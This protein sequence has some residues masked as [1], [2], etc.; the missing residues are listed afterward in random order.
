MA[1]PISITD[2]TPRSP[3]FATPT[4]FE[5]AGYSSL[6]RENTMPWYAVH[7]QSRFEAVAS[8]TLRAKGYE[9]F[10]PLYRSVRRWSDRRKQLDLPLFPG[11][12]FCRFDADRMLPILTTPGVVRIL[13]AGKKPIPVA[14]DEIA[15]VRRIL[16]SGYPAQPW[17]FLAIGS[18]VYLNGGPL[19]GLHGIVTSTDKNYRLVVSVGI[20]Q[21]SVAV[22]ID[23]DW[24]RPV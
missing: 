2:M 24:A 19:A 12:L 17:P 7:V 6:A 3:G 21:R 8:A 18:K 10:L 22:E 11:Y 13:S 5:A 23:R 15:S 14:E 9:E 1:S 20:L 16:A 4:G